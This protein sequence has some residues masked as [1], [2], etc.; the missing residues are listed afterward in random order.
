[1]N[2]PA[3]EWDLDP[4]SRPALTSGIEV[5]LISSNLAPEQR[6]IKIAIQHSL[7]VLFI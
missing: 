4:T 3:S 2:S 7:L 5:S 6:V 1:M